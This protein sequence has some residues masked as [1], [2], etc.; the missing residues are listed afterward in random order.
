MVTVELPFDEEQYYNLLMERVATSRI[1]TGGS[2]VADTEG[3]YD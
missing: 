1:K 3:S 2:T